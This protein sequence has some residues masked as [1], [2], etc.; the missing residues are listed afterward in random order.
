[1]SY[2]EVELMVD[3]ATLKLSAVRSR[4]NDAQRAIDEVEEQVRLADNGAKPVS[5]RLIEHETAQKKLL[6]DLTSERILYEGRI[7]TLT[8][9]LAECPVS[10]GG[11]RSDTKVYFPV[12]HR[13]QDKL[14]LKFKQHKSYPL[15]ENALQ[16]FC[17]QM[18][19]K[20]FV[21]EK[22]FLTAPEEA[23][24]VH[25]DGTQRLQPLTAIAGAR[26][27][28]VWKAENS[29]KVSTGKTY[30]WEAPDRA[31]FAWFELVHHWNSFQVD[32]AKLKLPPGV[33]PPKSKDR[34]KKTSRPQ[35][36]DLTASA[37]AIK[38][39]LAALQRDVARLSSRPLANRPRTPEAARKPA[40]PPR[41]PVKAGSVSS[42]RPPTP[43]SPAVKPRPKHQWIEA[44][45]G[46]DHGEK[47]FRSNT[48]PVE[49]RV[50]DVGADGT[51]LD[52]E[53]RLDIDAFYHLARGDL[54][55]VEKVV[56][57]KLVN[58]AFPLWAGSGTD[59][60]F[61]QTVTAGVHFAL[62]FRVL[63]IAA[64]EPG[65][66]GWTKG[67]GSQLQPHFVSGGKWS[68]DVLLKNTATL[69]LDCLADNR[70]YRDQVEQDVDQF[71][72]LFK[73]FDW[74]VHQNMVH[75][76]SSLCRGVGH[77]LRPPTPPATSGGE[78]VERLE[79]EAK[80]DDILDFEGDA[81]E[82]ED[83]AM[84]LAAESVTVMG[85]TYMQPPS[86]IDFHG[87]YHVA[88][89]LVDHAVAYPTLGY[90]AIVRGTK[91]YLGPQVQLPT[92]DDAEPWAPVVFKGETVPPSYGLK[93]V[94]KPVAAAVKSKAAAPVKKG[95]AKGFTAPK[96]PL[97][98]RSATPTPRPAPTPI[99]LVASA[100]ALDLI[101]PY[102][103][104]EGR[105]RTATSAELKFHLAVPAKGLPLGASWMKSSA[106]SCG[107]DKDPQSGPC[108]HVFARGTASGMNYVTNVR[109]HRN[110][111]AKKSPPPS[112]PA[113]KPPGRKEVAPQAAPVVASVPPQLQ[114]AADA[115]PLQA[116]NPLGVKGL[117]DTRS[118]V[119][120]SSALSLPQREQL[121][122]H[123]HPGAPSYSEEE[124]AALSVKER[125]DFASEFAIPKWATRLVLR[126]PKNLRKILKGDL[127]LEN[128]HLQVQDSPLKGSNVSMGERW[129]LLKEKYK[130]V[131][132]LLKPLSPREKA[133]RKEY[134]SLKATGAGDPALPR[135]KRRGGGRQTR[136]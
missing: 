117:A 42:K 84:A 80:G 93:T 50:G 66:L 128:F 134:E 51:E 100:P 122:K 6:G 96:S 5:L 12:F 61:H 83:Y 62:C 120:V 9:A 107:S 29:I 67:E 47:T 71:H 116:Q 72:L 127:T 32:D 11:L 48:F 98:S 19:A 73:E 111:A 17:D 60:E 8:S 68:L 129:K 124:F 52:V 105:G 113:G 77:T 56:L 102:K 115:D 37:D 75:T 76:F 88:G 4:I 49:K 130:G 126:D 22:M 82:F 103:D 101:P 44:S 119:A 40:S 89:P 46:E 131:D 57:A 54:K 87:D 31:L 7:S 59:A 112:V 58:P 106:C 15:T 25:P 39:L 53:Y 114:A 95:K 41:P 55:Q 36:E 109:A 1:M 21:P 20:G 118:N 2:S 64:H 99:G 79:F 65:M 16:V 97:A 34:A 13:T 18:A 30:K 133:F 35:D 86:V 81:A 90:I 121:R 110:E 92:E 10:S 78:D 38:K 24:I 70:Q 3:D 136:Q 91:I 135:P 123:F 125:R 63:E 85:H 43:P 104:A 69:A 23:V 132:L 27:L 28:E 108:R 94:R 74:D 26:L 45:R 33:H 14:V